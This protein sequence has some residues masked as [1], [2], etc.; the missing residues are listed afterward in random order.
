MKDGIVYVLTNPA[1]PNLVKIGITTR[2]Q[3]QIRM[4]ELYTT[5]VPLPFKCVYAGK[6]DNPKKVEGALHHAFL[7]SRVN[8]SREFF[9]IDESQAIAVLKLISNEEVTPIISNELDK[10]DEISKKA[11]KKYSRSKRPPLNFVEMGIKIGET[12][13]TA[14]GII[15]C[16][17]V[18][19]KKVEYENEIMSLTRLTRKLKDIDYDFQPGPH[20]FYNGKSL[21]DI[22]DETYSFED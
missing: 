3:V 12:I 10:V 6:V 15:S 1:F 13:S 21:K 2:D 19:E 20:W 5:G 7:N 22:Y 8:P 16:K 17:I 11:G 4:A 9:D 14:D 18:E